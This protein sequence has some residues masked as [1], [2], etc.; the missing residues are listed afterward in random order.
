MTYSVFFSYLLSYHTCLQYFRLLILFTSYLHICFCQFPKY[1]I[2]SVVNFLPHEYR[3][4][5]VIID[6]SSFYFTV[7]CFTLLYSALHNSTL[8]CTTLLYSTLS[9]STLSYPT[10]PYPTLPYPALHDT[11]LHYTHFMLTYSSFN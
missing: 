4:E 8:L 2:C 9:Y 7:T 6:I 3:S 11:T 1:Q 5:C 10:L